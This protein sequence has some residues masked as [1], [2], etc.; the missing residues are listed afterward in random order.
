MHERMNLDAWRQRREEMVREVEQS[1]LAKALR[2]GCKGRSN[3]VFLLTW[4][5][6]RVA[7]LLLKFSK[8]LKVPRKATR[9]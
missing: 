2:A 9:P 8:T 7:G 4:E 3:L 6:N 5:P 1:R